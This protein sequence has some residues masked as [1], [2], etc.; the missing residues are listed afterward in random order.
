LK[1]DEFSMSI[2]LSVIPPGSL[3]RRHQNSAEFCVFRD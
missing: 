2:V 3:N 1:I